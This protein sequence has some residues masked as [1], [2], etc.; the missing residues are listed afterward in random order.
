MGFGAPRLGCR[1]RD[2]LH[3]V[4]WLALIWVAL[5]VVWGSSERWDP[6]RTGRR[7]AHALD[8]RRRTDAFRRTH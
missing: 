7:V 3:D 2:D 5:I 8:L 6:V 4:L 1:H